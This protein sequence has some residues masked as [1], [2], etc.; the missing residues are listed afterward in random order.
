M[1]SLAL[2]FESYTTEILSL[3]LSRPHCV[4]N[5]SAFFFL[6]SYVYVIFVICV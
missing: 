4:L 5:L 6:D 1:S 3:L 2:L